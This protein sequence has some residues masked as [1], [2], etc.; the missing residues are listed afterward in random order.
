MENHKRIAIQS[1]KGRETPFFSIRKKILL[2]LVVVSAILI[3]SVVVT[4][5][6]LTTNRVERIGMQLSEQYVISTGE[7]LTETLN[8]LEEQ[9]DSVV[10]LPALR[11]LAMLENTEDA[12]SPPLELLRDVQSNVETYFAQHGSGAPSFDFLCIYLK[13]GHSYT[14]LNNRTV[15]FYDY[16]GCI[17]F[18]QNQGLTYTD[19]GY[20]S[21]Q[22]QMCPVRK[23]GTQQPV[24][25]RYLYAP[26]SMEKIGVVVFGLNDKILSDTYLRHEAESFILASSG[27]IIS[28]PSGSAIGSRNAYTDLVLQAILENDSAHGSITFQD[29]NGT[30]KT[31]FFYRLWSM[32]SY[33]VSPFE[34]QSSNWGREMTSYVFSILILSA[35]LILLA[36]CL[37]IA[38]SRGLTRSISSLVGFIKEVDMGNIDLRYQ[39]Q[40]NDEISNLGESINQMLDAIKH[41]NDIREEEVRANQVMELQLMQQQINPHL[42]YN[43]LNCVLWNLKQEEYG[44]SQELIRSLS[45]FFKLSLAHG[46]MEVPLSHELH[47]IEHYL[48][49]QNLAKNK[50]FQLNSNITQELYMHP[51]IKLTI[52]PLVENAVIHGFAGYCDDGVISVDADCADNI[53]RIAVTDNGLGI[54][55]EDI[56]Y[57][58]SVLQMPNCP[59]THRHFGLYN[60]NRRIVQKYGKPY[61]LTLE[62][63][64]CEY[65]KI[66]ITIPYCPDSE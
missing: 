60:I 25:L 34:L 58:E 44:H 64:P 4:S 13:N 47:L 51:I 55:K 14:H 23:N 3:L 54:S 1:K 19:F 26:V 21:T 28:S 29:T 39:K 7:L 20:E 43:T 15:P 62:S 50:R 5:Y 32:Q 12:A 40:S 22:W 16:S 48:A 57:L 38:F 11:E 52:Q 24:Y 37:S 8:L 10:L 66:T 18:F 45:E 6:T 36:I 49:I 17:R 56:A 2:S 33:L 59:K 35:A 41:I 30:Q 9:T 42:L 31:A 27:R 46:Q 53:V 65:T 63:Q 61:G